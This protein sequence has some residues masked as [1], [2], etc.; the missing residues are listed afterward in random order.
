M[1]D[2]T[3]R[4]QEGTPHRGCTADEDALHRMGYRDCAREAVR[5]LTQ[6]A[7][8]DPDSA[9][10]KGI[11][12]LLDGHTA[13]PHVIA[14]CAV[15]SRVSSEPGNVRRG[16]RT[17]RRVDD[18]ENRSTTARRCLHGDITRRQR[19]RGRPRCQH[20]PTAAVTGRLVTSQSLDDCDAAATDRTGRSTAAVG[21]E[22]RRRNPLRTLQSEPASSNSTSTS[23][24]DV[25]FPRTDDLTTAADVVECASMLVDLCQTDARVGNV[26]AELLQLMDSDCT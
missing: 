3:V 22:S 23:T 24:D 6:D 12:S 7:R 14:G 13:V 21:G 8:L 11:R 20:S 15:G 19:H 2:S 5:F 1:F 17:T 25:Q 10:V 4:L 9:V 16:R 18:G 26:L